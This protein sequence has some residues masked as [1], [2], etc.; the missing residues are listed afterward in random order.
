MTKIED[1][2]YSI[3]LEY[4]MNLESLINELNNRLKDL[5]EIELANNQLLGSLAHEKL[6]NY[7]F[8]PS[9]KSGEEI[10]TLSAELENWEKN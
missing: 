6:E 9:E 3:I 8:T 2:T 7:E 5:S 1:Y 10:A 4:L